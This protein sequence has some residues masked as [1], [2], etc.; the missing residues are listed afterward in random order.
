MHP[1]EH[2][3]HVARARGA[4]ADVLVR[5][6]ASG[7]AALR[8]EHASLV[9]ACRRIVER[10]PEVGPLWWM[11]ARL[12]TSPEPTRLAREIVGLVDDD[13]TPRRLAEALPDGATVLTAGWPETAGEGLLRRGDVTVL[14]PDGWPGSP[15][16]LS[17]LERMGIEAVSV[18]SE[19]LARAVAGADLVV[20]DAVAACPTRVLAPVG[21]SV[22][23]AVAGSV[24]VPV[25][26][27]AGVGRRLPSVF[28]DAIAARDTDEVLDELPVGLIDVVVGA[29]GA[30]ADLAVGLAPTCDAVPE[31]LRV[32]PL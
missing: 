10:H 32:G 24:G 15:R 1:I 8:A 14:C 20:V 11:C 21:S 6:A 7:L 19:T 27:V 25:W 18:P 12:L 29:E 3:R 2:L 9:I 13:P 23:A 22:V 31:L 26:V 16:F 5:E 30:T 17:R 4:G 28:V